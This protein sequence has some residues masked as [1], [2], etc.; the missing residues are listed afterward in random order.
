M[1]DYNMRVQFWFHYG[2][3]FPGEDKGPFRGLKTA[4]SG[5]TFVAC[6]HPKDNFE[7]ITKLNPWAHP[8]T[9]LN[10]SLDPNYNLTNPNP[11]PKHKPNLSKVSM[12]QNI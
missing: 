9:H 6:V 3:S 2:A 7:R 4:N 1:A 8:N 10:R 5:Y 12:F 11:I